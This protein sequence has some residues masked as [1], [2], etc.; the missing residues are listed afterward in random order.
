MT[1][2]SFVSYGIVLVFL[3]SCNSEERVSLEGSSYKL[4]Y[5]NTQGAAVWDSCVKLSTL[6]APWEGER[7]D[8]TV[9]QAYYDTV[10]VHFRFM[11]NDTSIAVSDSL[12]EEAVAMGDRVELFFSADTSLENYYCL[13]MAPGGR[14]LDYRASWYRKFDSGWNLEGLDLQSPHTAKGYTVTGSIP[15][16]FFRQL[17]GSPRTAGMKLKLG[18]FRAETRIGKEGKD[19]TWYSWINPGSKEPDFHI[20]AAFGELI[21]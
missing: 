15:V 8:G 16:A 7:A 11:V 4:Y 14:L 9:F 12:S 3:V 10:F 17:T 6:H 13:E 19:F 2:S 18:I 5:T 20:P 1:R 21:F